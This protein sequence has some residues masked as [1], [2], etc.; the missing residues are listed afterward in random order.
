MPQS[1]A[2]RAKPQL[3]ELKGGWYNYMTVGS[4]GTPLSKLNKTSTFRKVITSA[5]SI[6]Q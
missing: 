4:P 1:R 2:A 3:S 6:I 5:I